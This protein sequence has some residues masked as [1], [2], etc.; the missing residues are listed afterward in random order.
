MDPPQSDSAARAFG[1]R[2]YVD[3]MGRHQTWMGSCI[4]IIG[5]LF[6]RLLG[7]PHRPLSECCIPRRCLVGCDGGFCLY[8]CRT[9]GLVVQRVG[10][11]VVSGYCG[12]EIRR[13]HHHIPMAHTKDQ[14]AGDGPGGSLH[15]RSDVPDARYGLSHR[16]N[17]GREPWFTDPGARNIGDYDYP[18]QRSS[19]PG[20]VLQEVISWVS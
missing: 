11:S 4:R 15:R 17:H 12:Y 9:S 8:I 13:I 6:D 2:F 20:T 18:G 19:L 1:S 10:G 3:G 5:R 16:R 14:A 7:W